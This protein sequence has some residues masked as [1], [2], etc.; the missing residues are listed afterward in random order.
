MIGAKKSSFG[1]EHGVVD[2]FVTDFQREDS[3]A[4]VSIRF[5]VND[6]AAH[7]HG[8]VVDSELVGVFPTV[9]QT[10]EDRYGNSIRVDSD[11]NGKKRARSSAGPLADLKH[12]DNAIVWSIKE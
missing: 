1:D 10:I 4:G 3:P 9:G 7:V 8:P 2:V 6:A 11:L 12:G 5:N